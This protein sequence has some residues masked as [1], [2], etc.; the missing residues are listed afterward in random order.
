MVTTVTATAVTITFS[1]ETAIE[2][3]KIITLAVTNF[4]P[5]TTAPDITG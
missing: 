4:A 1:A 2:E 3:G 5:E